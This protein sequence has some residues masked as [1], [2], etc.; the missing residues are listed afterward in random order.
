MK[1]SLPVTLF[2]LC[3]RRT[4]KFDIPVNSQSIE[5]NDAFLIASF[6]DFSSSLKSKMKV[7]A[8]DSTMINTY[9]QPSR[10]DEHDSVS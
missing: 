9:G 4:V 6:R 5:M 1:Y 8:D 2:A 3:K 7:I 10:D